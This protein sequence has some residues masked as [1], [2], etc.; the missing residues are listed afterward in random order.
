MKAAH[1]EE[2]IM[3]I[4]DGYGRLAEA[5][6]EGWKRYLYP[7]ESILAIVNF[8]RQKIIMYNEFGILLL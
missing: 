2:E 1:Q 3:P 6:S 5:E 8:S 4:L 7:N